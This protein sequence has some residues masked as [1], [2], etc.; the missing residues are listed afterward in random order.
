MENYMNSLEQPPV[1]PIR[2]T[3]LTVLC[4]LTFVGS[5]WTIFSGLST[6]LTA[7]TTANVVQA[8]MQDAQDEISK[9]NSD[10]GSR[11]AEKMLSGVSDV[12]KPE[13]LKKSALFSIISS[14]FTLVGAILMFQLKK[15][16]FWLYVLGV[17]IAIIA[18]MVIFGANNLVSMMSTMGAAVIGIIFVILYAMNLKHLK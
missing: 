1:K 13:N 9:G 3:F 12:L 8:A 16:G 6:Y 14:I 7:D 10:A 5:G 4:I 11:M 15:P 2:P 18:P 17:I